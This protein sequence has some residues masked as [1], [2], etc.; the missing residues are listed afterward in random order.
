MQLKEIQDLLKKTSARREEREFAAK[1]IQNSP[2]GCAT[3]MKAILQGDREMQIKGCWVL[4]I[5]LLND[6]TLLESHAKRFMNLIGNLTH[7]SAIRPVAK[8]LAFWCEAAYSGKNTDYPPLDTNEPE[9]MAKSCFSWMLEDHPVAVKVYSMEA[10]FHLG[11]EMSW[12]HPELKA[13]LLKHYANQSPG[14]QARAKRLL[15]K[16]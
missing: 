1:I 8:I 4:E 9:R 10:L 12:I 2:E 3:L 15:K 13:Y 11:K 7:G 5:V 6:P 16:L 14:F